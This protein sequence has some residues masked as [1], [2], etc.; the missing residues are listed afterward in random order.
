M[1]II[2]TKSFFIDFFITTLIGTGFFAIVELM[3]VDDPNSRYFVHSIV[4]RFN[5][6]RFCHS[7][8]RASKR[9]KRI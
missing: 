2:L 9:E 5:E 3:N 7:N 4:S 1:L 8:V 6:L